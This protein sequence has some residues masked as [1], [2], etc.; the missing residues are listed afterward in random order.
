[1]LRDEISSYVRPSGKITPEMR[2]QMVER[3]TE[4]SVPSTLCSLIHSI[5]QLSKGN[6]AFSQ[7]LLFVVFDALCC[8]LKLGGQLQLKFTQF[9]D[10]ISA[11]LHFMEMKDVKLKTFGARAIWCLCLDFPPAQDKLERCGGLEQLMR[12]LEDPKGDVFL[13][14]QACGAVWG[15]CRNNPLTSSRLHQLSAPQA[16][17]AIMQ[18]QTSDRVLYAAAGALAGLCWKNVKV[19]K[20]LLS[21]PNHAFFHCLKKLLFQQNPSP[22]LLSQAVELTSAF[23]LGNETN[24]ALLKQAGYTK[25]LVT[26]LQHDNIGVRI[27]SAGA[28]YSLAETP[29][30]QE[31]IGVEREGILE[32]CKM[33]N[34][35]TKGSLL[36][37]FAAL[38]ALGA[39]LKDSPVNQKKLIELHKSGDVDIRPSLEKL[40]GF[41]LQNIEKERVKIPCVL[42]AIY[43]MSRGEHRVN[44]VLAHPS[45]HVFQFLLQTL[46]G[47]HILS[48]VKIVAARAVSALSLNNHI[49]SHKKVVAPNDIRKL[50]RLMES[51]EEGEESLETALGIAL[52]TLCLP[53]GSK[54]SSL[55]SSLKSSPNVSNVMQDI[56]NRVEH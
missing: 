37:P 18:E 51:L 50:C 27:Q 22:F 6:Q 9:S 30:L 8:M 34:R 35:H 32:L 19:Q 29:G 43:N 12:L 41:L 1:M 44:E 25:L 2:E 24:G 15:A 7:E 14:E 42:E 4:A 10:G 21:L 26:F 3:I 17:I 13:L 16:L 54:S 39:L 36:D 31:E 28:I 11:I 47:N 55:L 49:M 56:A 46:L 23:V 5:S 20:S 53:V 40:F 52:A 38:S 33:M 48:P 45:T